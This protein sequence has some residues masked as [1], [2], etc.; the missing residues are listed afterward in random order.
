MML[1]MKIFNSI[2]SFLILFII[3]FLIFTVFLIRIFYSKNKTEL[4]QYSVLSGIFFSIC[5]VIIIIIIMKSIL[6]K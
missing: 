6:K 3:N 1:Y 2:I 5:I 4:I